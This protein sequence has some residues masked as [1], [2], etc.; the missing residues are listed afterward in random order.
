[1]LCGVNNRA[2]MDYHRFRRYDREREFHATELA[3][4][5]ER[6]KETKAKLAEAERLNREAVRMQKRME[7]IIKQ[8]MEENEE[9]RGSDDDEAEDD[10]ERKEEDEE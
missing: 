1:M 8:L 7:D 9:L 4:E 2:P 6:V 10:G 5:R 3:A